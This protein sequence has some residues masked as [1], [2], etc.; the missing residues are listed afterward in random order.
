[1]SEKTPVVSTVHHRIGTKSLWHMKGGQQLPA[2]IQNV[3]HAFI[4]NGTPE[5]RA[6]ARAV[7]VVKDWAAGR[8]PNGKGEVSPTVQA[9][10][11]RAIAEWESLKAKAKADNHANETEAVELSTVHHDADGKFA[12]RPA[13]RERLLRAY[14]RQM[15][16]QV[17]GEMD[18]KTSQLLKEAN[19]SQADRVA[20]AQSANIDN[21]VRSFFL[22][23]VNG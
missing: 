8:M 23:S 1:M 22:R 20:A 4:R 5:S 14:Q 11:A 17:T 12:A 9:A 3:A 13:E 6:I 10:A 16:L 15:G 2:Y 7:G 18:S 21:D 19:Q